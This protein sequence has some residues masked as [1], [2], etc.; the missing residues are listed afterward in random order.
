MNI[1]E[2]KRVSIVSFEFILLLP[3]ETN[4]EP[5]GALFIC[6]CEQAQIAKTVTCGINATLISEVSNTVAIV[7]FNELCKAL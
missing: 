1:D 6:V 3:K 2:R 5:C 4:S 7:K